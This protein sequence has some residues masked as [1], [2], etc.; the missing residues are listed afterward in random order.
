[1]STEPWVSVEDAAKHL[2]VAKDSIYR[3]YVVFNRAPSD[4]SLSAVRA[5][6]VLDK[7]NALRRGVSALRRGTPD[8]RTFLVPHRAMEAMPSSRIAYWASPSIRRAMASCAPLD[9]DLASTRQGLIT[10]D[11]NR[12][13][14]LR[15]EVPVGEVEVDPVKTAIRSNAWIPYAKGGA[16]SPYF[17]DVHLIVQWGRDGAEIKSTVDENGRQASRPQESEL[18]LC[19]RRDLHGA[20]R[21]WL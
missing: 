3:A 7:E 5:L 10:A 17:G 6:D 11:N 8:K 1:M 4:G 16:Y 21:Q 20:H 15:W 12:F 18:L 2:S 13:L 9:P 19:R 14:R